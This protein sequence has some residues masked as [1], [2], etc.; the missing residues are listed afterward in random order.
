MRDEFFDKTEKIKTMKIKEIYFHLLLVLKIQ[1]FISNI[2]L[3]FYMEIYFKNRCILYFCFYFSISFMARFF[4]FSCIYHLKYYSK[5]NPRLPAKVVF[6]YQIQN[7]N[8]I[9]PNDKYPSHKI[10]RKRLRSWTVEIRPLMNW[11][12]MNFR[13]HIPRKAEKLSSFQCIESCNQQGGGARTS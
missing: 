8:L 3:F 2:F 5:N 9:N 10:Q 13:G 12:H 1:K 7:M 11:M 6:F 4:C